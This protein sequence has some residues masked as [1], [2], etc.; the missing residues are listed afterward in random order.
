MFLRINVL[1]AC[2]HKTDNLCDTL[3]SFCASKSFV[4]CDTCIL[5]KQCTKHTKLVADVYH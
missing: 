5:C 2:T 4:A 1:H 3:E